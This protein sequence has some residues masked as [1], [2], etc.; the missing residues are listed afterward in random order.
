MTNI[1]IK[2]GI[3]TDITNKITNAS[4]T[5]VNV[6]GRMKTVV[7]YVDQE[8]QNI[9]SIVKTKGVVEAQEIG[10]YPVLQF[11]LNTVITLGTNRRVVLKENPLIGEEVLVFANNNASS[12]IVQADQAATSKISSGGISSTAGTLSIG[13][14]ISVKFIHLGNGFWKASL[15]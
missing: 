13:S 2:S 10:P 1:Q 7:D 15:L 5:P 8:I 4:I 11:N 6:G 14:N 3:D 9:S 12:F